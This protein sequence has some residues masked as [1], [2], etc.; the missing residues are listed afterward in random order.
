MSLVRVGDLTIGGGSIFTV[1]PGRPF[2]FTVTRSNP[3]PRHLS[4][5]PEGPTLLLKIGNASV[6]TIL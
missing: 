1:S 4:L 6:V 2:G 3:Q 5:H